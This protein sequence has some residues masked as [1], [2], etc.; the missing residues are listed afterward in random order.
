M[1]SSINQMI[2]RALAKVRRQELVQLTCQLVN[3]PSRTGEE[4]DCAKFLVD[5]EQA[6]LETSYQEVNHKRGNA[7]GLLPGGGG[8]PTLIFNGHLDT[9]FT[10]IEDEDYPATG[11]LSPGSLP[12]A[13]VE[14]GNIYR[15]GVYNMKAGLAAS[16]V[17]VKTIK[18]AGIIPKGNIVVTG[19]AGE[20]ENVLN[21]FIEQGVIS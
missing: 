2:K 12:A 10:G 14:A 13:R 3:I 7:V 18:Q 4:G 17:A 15:L 11:P 9:S 8:G 16:V 19:V 1:R 20:V 6:G 21:F 5:Y